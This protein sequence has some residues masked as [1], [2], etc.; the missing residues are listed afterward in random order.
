M[1]T[2]IVN[3]LQELIVIHNILFIFI[4][5]MKSIIYQ[6]NALVPT[7][8]LVSLH[9]EIHNIVITASMETV[10]LNHKLNTKKNQQ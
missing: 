8:N 9:K 1:E 10:I 2:G 5:L 7:P 6:H 3:N 4:V